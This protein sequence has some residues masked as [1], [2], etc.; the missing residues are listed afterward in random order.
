M[1]EKI[2]SRKKK[3]TRE[4]DNIDVYTYRGTYPYISLEPRLRLDENPATRIV[5]IF[6]SN[7]FFCTWISF[8]SNIEWER[9]RVDND[10]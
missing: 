3:E 7:P 10:E 1:K 8:V 5:A 9:E 4:R 2:K 6:E